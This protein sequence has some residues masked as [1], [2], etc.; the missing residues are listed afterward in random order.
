MNK[1]DLV[2]KIMGTTNLSK[3]DSEAAVSAVINS[4]SDALANGDKVQ[5]MGFGTFEIRSRAERTGRNP[6]TGE[7]ITIP[8]AKVPVFKAGSKL[9]E[10]VKST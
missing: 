3:K 8:E 7:T 4:I 9:K 5:L 6:Q 2:K 10:L 1:T